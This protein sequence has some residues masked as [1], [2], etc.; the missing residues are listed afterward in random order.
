MDLLDKFQ[1]IFGEAV[2][3]N[4]FEVYSSM[5]IKKIKI[6]LNRELTDKEVLTNFEE[7]ILQILLDTFSRDKNKY[8]EGIQSFSQGSRSVSFKEV[9]VFNSNVKS[10]LPLPSVKMK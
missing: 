1:A 6:Y 4:K 8:V 3:I 9:L 10:L 7:A 5:A 2:D